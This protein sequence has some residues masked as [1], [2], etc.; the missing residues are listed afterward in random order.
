[1]D[2]DFQV[3]GRSFSTAS[4]VRVHERSRINAS[5]HHLSGAGAAI[6]DLISD[7]DSTEGSSSGSEGHSDYEPAVKHSVTTSVSRTSPPRLRKTPVEKVKHGA[8]YNY[9]VPGEAKL[10]NISVF[11]GT[12][13]KTLGRVGTHI[14]VN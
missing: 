14:F 8:G 7:D 5:S 6:L 11:W 13:P 9:G 4:D 2:S 3:S 1:M 12:G 10:K